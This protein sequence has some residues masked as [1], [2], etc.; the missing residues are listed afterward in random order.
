ML[1]INEQ[2]LKD[3]EDACPICIDSYDDDPNAIFVGL[4]KK[5]GHYFHF[6]CLWNWLE[7]NQTCPICRVTC[8][9]A[10]SDLQG[11]SLKQ[12]LEVTRSHDNHQANP[13]NMASTSTSK[14]DVL[15]NDAPLQYGVH[16]SR[17]VRHESSSAS[18]QTS[19][20]VMRSQVVVAAETAVITSQ[21]RS[22]TSSSSPTGSVAG[23]EP[24]RR[25]RLI[26]QMKR[27][28]ESGDA[29]DVNCDINVRDIDSED[30]NRRISI[31]SGTVS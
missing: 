20:D 22:L 8:D 4:V 23:A 17:H 12:V 18:S 9:L 25:S 26:E 14:L 21:P 1:S 6:E 19:N 3:M 2:V 5:C 29:S 10:E 13:N 16:V 7:L 31:N 15:F 24:F 30:D 11:L 28:F 27:R